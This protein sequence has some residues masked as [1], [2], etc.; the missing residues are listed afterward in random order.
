MKQFNKIHMRLIAIITAGA[1]LLGAVGYLLVSHFSEPTDSEKNKQI[2]SVKGASVDFGF[3]LNEGDEVTIKK[4]N[5]AEV[6]P[7]VEIYAYDF[8]LSSGQ[9]DGVIE[10][11]ISYSDKGLKEDEE[12]ISVCGKYLNPQTGEWEDVFYTVDPDS[13]TVRILTDHLSTY[14]VFKITNANKRSAYISEVNIYAANMTTRQAAK[15]LEAYS[16]QAP[17]WRE[18]VVSAAMEAL[19]SHEY[20]AATSVPTLLSLG[21]AYDSIIGSS[22]GDSLTVLGVS[23]ACAQFAYDSYN[24]GLDSKEASLSGMKAV[25]NLSVSLANAP[26]QLAYVGVGV[27]DLAL[28]DV[29]TFAVSNKYKST[30]NMYDAYYRRS[31][32]QRN[33]S[34]WL[35]LF[36]KM[37]K[38]NK[39]EPEKVL[40]LMQAEID[41]YVQE[42][43]TVAGTDWESW[44]DSYDKNGKLSKY[45]WPQEKDRNNI[46]NIHKSELYEYL[47][48]VFRRIS[49]NMYLD[50]LVERQKDFQKLAD[51]Y[52]RKFSLVIRE[53]VP[54]GK[55]P[56]WAGY[57]ARLAPISKNV[58]S[59]SW[60]GKLNEN[61]GGRI[62]FTLLAHQTAGFPM[63]FELYKTAADAREGKNKLKTITLHPFTESEQT[64]LLQPKQVDEPEPEEPE[65]E[66]EPK[67]EPKPPI[68]EENPWYD[69][70]VKAL[71]NS[72]VFSGWSAVLQYPKDSSPDL[73][74]M[75]AEFDRKGQCLLSF[76][77]SDYEGL[78]SPS[79]I[80]LYKNKADLLNKAKPDQ[81]VNFSLASA[82]Y[83]G[84]YSG[85][86]LYKLIVK[87]KPPEEKPDILEGITG[88]YSSYLIH[89]EYFTTGLPEK[90]VKDYSP[91]EEPSADVN[92]HYNGP[93]L[94]YISAADPYHTGKVLEKSSDS[95]YERTETDG[96]STTYI[97]IEIISIGSSAKLFMS[98]DSPGTTW[99]YE[100]M[101]TR[102]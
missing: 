81:V 42:Y 23:T 62:S 86:P 26:I 18:D 20:F 41:R 12:K 11:A 85:E 78:E 52:N 14:A 60:I 68:A 5:P 2:I 80:W 98:Y 73:Y 34:D 67:P 38:D 45:P 97:R 37:Y 9:P 61:G 66:P 17:T 90:I 8:M 10:I 89:S 54:S 31:G 63:N 79:Q 69:V 74:F 13:N 99:Q 76:Q 19:G 84:E 32:I 77:R 36:E 83:A 40:E 15:I 92:L 16:G 94:T 88:D 91:G 50:S 29:S 59:S 71:D 93:S 22:L 28:T 55:S 70:T 53:E 95:L 75:L 25:L 4:V 96:S 44:I 1:L 21:G 72:K 87:A 47:G 100:Y 65:P 51:I 39:N 49:R 24:Y 30:K 82:S 6:D 27:I 58:D 56:T 43:W 35:K 57:Y 101:L 46:S 3:L 102:K 7:D 64:V 33:S 48:N